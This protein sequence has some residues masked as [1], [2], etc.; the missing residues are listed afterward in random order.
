MFS[1]TAIG[2]I[3]PVHKVNFNPFILSSIL[4]EHQSVDFPRLFLQDRQEALSFILAYGYDLSKVE[5]SQKVWGYHRQAIEILESELLLPDEKIPESLRNR[6]ELGDITKLLLVAS[7]S[8]SEQQKWACAILRVMHVLI[9]LD[10]DIFTSFTDDIKYQI[11]KPISQHIHKKEDKVFLGIGDERIELESYEEKSFK[12]THSAVVKLLARHDLIA[13]T[14]LDRVGIRFVTQNL[15]D[16]FRVIQY[17]IDNHLI[18]YPQVISSMSKNTVCPT[19]VFMTALESSMSTGGKIDLKNLEDK[20]VFELEKLKT[21]SDGINPF[22]SKDFKF[23]KFITRQ[24]LKISRGADKPPFSFFYP[25]EIQIL[26]KETYDKNMTGPA[27]HHEYKNRQRHAA[28]I[29]VFN[30]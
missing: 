18:S 28:R 3:L 13:M 5:D 16:I 21:K 10:N 2:L 30:D 1:E 22:T 25:F 23:L 20:I 15:V 4:G 11:L 19:P 26:D 9:H 8:T 29:R 14:L 6:E 7:L 12:Q 17:L 27:S 24:F